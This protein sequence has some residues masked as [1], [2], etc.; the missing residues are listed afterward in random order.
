MKE[1]DILGRESKMLWP[2]YIFPGVKTPPTPRIYAPDRG[3]HWPGWLRELIG[4]QRCHSPFV[5]L[6]RVIKIH[7]YLVEQS[8]V[9]PDPCSHTVREAA[10]ICPAPASP[11]KWCPSHVSHVTWATILV[12]GSVFLDLGPM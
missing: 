7:V 6:S 5:N 8:S 3:F 4:L 12:L 2:S 1:C 9:H 10:T 11:W